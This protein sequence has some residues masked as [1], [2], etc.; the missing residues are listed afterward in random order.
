VEI[1]NM[2]SFRAVQ[3]AVEFEIQR[4]IGLLEEGGKLVQETR[5]WNE[6]KGET[7]SMRSKEFAHDYRYFPEPDLVPFTIS[8]TE[9]EAIRKTLP[10]LPTARA[11][12]LMKEYGISEK[13]AFNLVA[14]KE[15][16]KY[17]EA[18]VK[19][20]VNPKLAANWIQ[21]ELLGILNQRGLTVDKCPVVARDTAGLIRL[22]ENN[23]ISGKIAKDVYPA[24]FET[25]KSAEEIVKD[26]G[27][28][29]VTDTKLIEEI[30]ERV[31]QANPRSAGDYRGGKKEAL[32]YLVGQVMKE[33]KG[34]A[35]PKMVNEILAKKLQ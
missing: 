33:T 15:L 24:M 26:R 23:T 6:S 29:Q 25:G 35:N 16:V 20:K 8:R 4:Q 11:E 18:C 1:K 31:I 2:N 12:R 14:D 3:K 27:L 5:L 19:E 21:S 10:E 30:A 28:V 13:D 17:Y 32:G 9:V 22:I 7:F 34:K